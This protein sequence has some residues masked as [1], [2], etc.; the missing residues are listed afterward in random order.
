MRGS[1]RRRA[2]WF[3]ILPLLL[4]GS[5]GAQ[6]V[7]DRFTSAS[8]RGAELLAPSHTNLLLGIAGIGALLLGSGFVGHVASG[9]RDRAVSLWIFALLPPI[10]F[11]VQEHVE[12]WVGHGALTGSPATQ[13]AFLVGLALQAPFTIAAYVAA[14]LLMRLA[15]AVADHRRPEQ[16]ASEPATFCASP[17]RDQPPR[18]I[19]L[20]GSRITRGPPALTV[21]SF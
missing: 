21:V 9:C 1:L 3:T 6:A 5:E 14:R 18:R 19:Q 17:D 15:E 8:Y 4:A 13:S 16:F 20:H 7:L 2:L 11:V 12:Y 10:V